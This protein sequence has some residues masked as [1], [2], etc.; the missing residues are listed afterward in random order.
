M[1]SPAGPNKSKLSVHT[2]RSIEQPVESKMDAI[3]N[4]LLENLSWTSKK[5]LSS[6]NWS[7]L[8]CRQQDRQIL[9]DELQQKTFG[10]DDLVELKEL[11]LFVESKLRKTEPNMIHTILGSIRQH[12]FSEYKNPSDEW[13]AINEL[14]TQKISEIYRPQRN[15]KDIKLLISHLD[16][17]H[18]LTAENL[19][20]ASGSDDEINEWLDNENRTIAELKDANNAADA[21]KRLVKESGKKDDRKW[22]T[23]LLRLGDSALEQEKADFRDELYKSKPYCKDL[24][25]LLNKVCKLQKNKMNPET[26]AGTIAPRLFQGSSLDEGIMITD[27]RNQFVAWMILHPDEDFD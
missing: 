4:K 13:E 2:F 15:L 14:I 21:L 12:L 7:D 5:P 10:I 20:L 17:P 8:I 6:S 16:N 1:I 24:F 27:F 23:W 18:F 25:M 3:R 22:V 19:F 11:Q 9:M 26:L